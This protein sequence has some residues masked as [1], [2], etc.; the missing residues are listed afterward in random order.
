LF[1]KPLTRQKGVK[2]T[3]GGGGGFKGIWKKEKKR[4]PPQFKVENEKERNKKGKIGGTKKKVLRKSCIA[5]NAR[6][7]SLEEKKN[8]KR[9]GIQRKG[10]KKK[11]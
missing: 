9:G 10:C 11:T 1:V 3:K 6:R 8:L 2:K 7:R 5:A 4:L